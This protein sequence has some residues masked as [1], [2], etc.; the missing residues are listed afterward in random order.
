MGDDDDGAA[1]GPSGDAAVRRQR[2]QAAAA[3]DH[4]QSPLES[5]PASANINVTEDTGDETGSDGDDTIAARTRT[6]FSL[7][8]VPI[9]TLESFLPD[10]VEPVSLCYFALALP[11]H[12]ASLMQL[13]LACVCVCLML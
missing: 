9:D 8:D 1:V 3:P 4:R 6:K 11:F 12:T 7:V 5:F 2:E 13:S 10:A